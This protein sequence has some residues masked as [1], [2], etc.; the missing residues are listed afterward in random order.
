VINVTRAKEI[1]RIVLG[2]FMDILLELDT[3]VELLS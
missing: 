2:V 3:E 1:S